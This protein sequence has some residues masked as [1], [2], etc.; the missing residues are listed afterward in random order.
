MLS[1]PFFLIVCKVKLST[2]V[3]GDTKALFSIATTPRCRG[4][5]Y[6]FPWIALLYPYLIMLSVKQ[7]GIRYYFKSL[8]YDV[9]WDC[10]QVSRTIAE[11]STHLA[12]D[13]VFFISISII[14]YSLLYCL[15]FTII[16][17]N[18]FQSNMLAVQFNFLYYAVY[19]I[20]FIRLTI[21]LFILY[22][23]VYQFFLVLHA[24]CPPVFLYYAV[25]LII[26][27]F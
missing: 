7:G 5:R 10:T 4:G 19:S 6:S 14:L 26:F 24:V 3:G 16:Y 18:S 1:T 2:V 12:N 20:A 21:L 22:Y 11:H 8:S 25:Y 27:I 23:D 13:P 17:A 15:H 9:T